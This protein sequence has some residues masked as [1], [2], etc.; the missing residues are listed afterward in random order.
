M[1]LAFSLAHCCWFRF[2]GFAGAASVCPLCSRPQAHQRFR[3]DLANTLSGYPHRVRGFLKSVL[4]SGFVAKTENCSVSR[5]KLCDVAQ[6][7]E[8]ALKIAFV[9][10]LFTKIINAWTHRCSAFSSTI[11]A[12]SSTTEVYP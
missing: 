1:K 4:V 7:F 11:L 10:G 3:F 5:V 9:E 2:R 12:Q 8:S 6:L